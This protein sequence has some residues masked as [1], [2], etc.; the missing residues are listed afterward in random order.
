MSIKK[1][2]ITKSKDDALCI[3]KSLIEGHKITKEDLKNF[4]CII[5]SHEGK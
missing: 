2:I 3:I 4:D 5:E 1:D